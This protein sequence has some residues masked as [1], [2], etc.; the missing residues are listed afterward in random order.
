V[1]DF[2][3]TIAGPHCTRMLSDM[4]AEVI[5]IE[6]AE[7]ETMRTRP[8]VRDDCSTVFGG[9]NVGK[10]SVVLDLKSPEGIQAIKKLVAKVDVLVENFRP[11]VMRRL[12]LDHASLRQLNPK[13]IY[14]SISGYGQTRASAELRPTPR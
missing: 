12:K 7:G 4:G 10:K 13:L 3:T 14:C 6:T 2:S 9:Y 1:L 8:P 5:K 11:G